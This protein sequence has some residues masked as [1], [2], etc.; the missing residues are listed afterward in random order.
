MLGAAVV[1]VG[2]DVVRDV[3][4]VAFTT[5]AVARRAAVDVVVVVKGLEDVFPVAAGTVVDS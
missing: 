5:V 3:V 4:M 2:L 1:V